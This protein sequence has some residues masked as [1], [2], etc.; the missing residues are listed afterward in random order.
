LFEKF[1]LDRN[2]AVEDSISSTKSPDRSPSRNP[3]TSPTRSAKW[4]VKTDVNDVCSVG[5]IED[6]VKEME[7]ATGANFLII[8]SNEEKTN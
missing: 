3:D 7:E 6:M 8:G 1:L 4:S 2:G 5:D